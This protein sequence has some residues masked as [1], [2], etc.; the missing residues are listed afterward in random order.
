[1]FSR[2]FPRS[3]AESDRCELHEVAIVHG[4]QDSEDLLRLARSPIGDECQLCAVCR[5]AR[6][7]VERRLAEEAGGVFPPEENAEAAWRKLQA[8]IEKAKAT[9]RRAR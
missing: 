7:Y 3:M 1:M 6:E 5:D 2:V 4:A 8:A 9:V